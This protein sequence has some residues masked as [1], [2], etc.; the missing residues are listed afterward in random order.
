MKQARSK[1]TAESARRVRQMRLGLPVGMC[2]VPH[3]LV[4]AAQDAPSV[5]RAPN[6]FSCIDEEHVLLSQTAAHSVA[7]AAYPAYLDAYTG[8]CAPCFDAFVANA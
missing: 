5:A 6:L 8:D 3:A 7:L 1:E 2:C 4:A